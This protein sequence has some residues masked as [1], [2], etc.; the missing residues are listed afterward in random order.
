MQKILKIAIKTLKNS[1]SL[2]IIIVETN[3]LLTFYIKIKKQKQ[4]ASYNNASLEGVMI[5]EMFN[6]EEEIELLCTGTETD[7]EMFDELIEEEQ[8][9]SRINL[10]VKNL[11]EKITALKHE[12]TDDEYLAKLLDL[13]KK[14]GLKKEIAELQIVKGEY[15]YYQYNYNNAIKEYLRALAYFLEQKQFEQVARMYNFIGNSYY[16]QMMINQALIYYTMAYNTAISH[17]SINNETVKTEAIFNQILCYR[18]I[19]RHDMALQYINE[20]KEKSDKATL[21][22]NDGKLT[23]VEANTYRDLKDYEKAEDLYNQLLNNSQPLDCN[24]LFLAYLNCGTLYQELGEVEKALEYCNKA[25]ELKDE[26]KQSYVPNIYLCYA[27]C[28][29]MLGKSEESLKDLEEGIK[30]AVKMNKDSLIVDFHFTIVLVY[31]RLKQNY[32]EALKHLKEVEKIILNKNIKSKQEKLYAFYSEI[33]LMMEDKEKSI[34][35]LHK[36]QK[37][38]LDIS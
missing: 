17:R 35:Y 15:F 36:M 13:A 5:M 27:K 28:K 20:L 32:N 16:M 26:V 9:K 21:C 14:W 30:L 29:F 1:S 34:E 37:N 23:L 8:I 2:G 7:K 6:S 25:Y 22:I 11:R 24:T 19:H 10:E 4:I 18:Y 38:Y 3:I 12:A 33:Y 31:M